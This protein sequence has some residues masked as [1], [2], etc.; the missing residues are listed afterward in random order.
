MKYLLIA[1]SIIFLLLPTSVWSVPAGWRFPNQNDI[2]GEWAQHRDKLSAPYHIEADFNLDG[3]VDDIWLLIK[4]NKKGWGLFAFIS[5]E[6]G[7]PFIVKIRESLEEAP[8][9]RGILYIKPGSFQNTACG[10]GI[11]KCYPGDAYQLMTE[12]PTFEF[13]RYEGG[14]IFYTWN[15]EKMTFV[16]DTLED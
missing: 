10:L 7:K 1:I 11:P 8:Q 13:F 6:S 2:I 15:A 12:K 4:Q 5:S 9:N 16:G 3:T 14:N